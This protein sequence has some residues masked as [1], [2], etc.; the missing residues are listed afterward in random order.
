[1]KNYIPNISG[2]ADFCEYHADGKPIYIV[3]GK[4]RHSL[5]LLSDIRYKYNFLFDCKAEIEKTIVENMHMFDVEETK[6]FYYPN[7]NMFSG[8]NAI[9]NIKGQ[10][11][12]LKKKYR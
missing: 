8:N 1:M 12:T 11:L 5:C 3:D 6:G 2:F 4:L 7:D 10:I 9:R